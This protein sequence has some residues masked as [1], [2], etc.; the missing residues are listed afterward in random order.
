LADVRHFHLHRRQ[1][2][3]IVG[4]IDIH[5][6]GELLLIA[7]ALGL[8]GAGLGLREGGQKQGGQNRDDRDDDQQFDESESGSRTPK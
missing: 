5:R 3:S 8:I 2:V 4:A 6:D 7:Q 1:P